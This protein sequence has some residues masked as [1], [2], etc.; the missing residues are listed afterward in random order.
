MTPLKT[1]TKFL[2]IGRLNVPTAL[3]IIAFPD[4]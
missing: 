4:Q 1:Q 2:F 3:S